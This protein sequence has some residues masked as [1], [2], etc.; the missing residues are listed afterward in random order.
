M[1]KGVRYRSAS[2]RVTLIPKVLRKVRR[3]FGLGKTYFTEQLRLIDL[4]T[5]NDYSV[6][7]QVKVPVGTTHFAFYAHAAGDADATPEDRFRYGALEVRGLDSYSG[8][9]GVS[10]APVVICDSDEP[11]GGSAKGQALMRL[12]ND[13]M[14]T[15]GPEPAPDDRLWTAND[16]RLREVY[17]GMCEFKTLSSAN[18]ER[19]L[20]SVYRQVTMIPDE[21]PG[22]LLGDA[23]AAKIAAACTATPAP[24]SEVLTLSDEYQGFPADLYLPEGAA[25]MVWDADAKLYVTPA[26]QV[27]GK[28]LDIPSMSDYVFPANLQYLA[29]SPL[30]ASDSLALPGNETDPQTSAT[31][32]QNWQE[33]ISD[34]YADGYTTVSENTQSVAMVDQAHYSVGRLDTQVKLESNTLYDAFGKAIDCTKG[35]TLKGVLVSGQHEVGYDFEPIAG[36]PE[37]VLYDTDIYGGPQHVSLSYTPWNHT[38]GLATPAD[39]NELLALELVNDGPDFQGADGRIAHGATFYLVANL[40]PTAATNYEK[41]TRDRIFQR[42]HVTYVSMKVLKGKGDVNGDGTPDTDRNND[43]TPDVYTFDP[44]TGLPDGIDADGDGQKEDEYD[45]NGD[46][47][48][49]QIV[50]VDSNGDGKPDTA[51][52][53]TNGDGTPD[54]PILPDADGNWPDTPTEP[55]GLATAT[56]GIPTLTDKNERRSFGLSVDLSWGEG[57]VFDD[58]PL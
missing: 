40:Q 21:Y 12:L 38:L 33:L 35:F 24:A 26:A 37:H 49:D 17:R 11:Q 20:G 54:I 50:T 10:F 8:N 7:C 28:G 39:G 36:T 46:G 53:D 44:V 32:Y 52:W 27:Y 2:R 23:I 18:V 16:E 9:S 30:V 5:D 41:G 45:I 42:D 31:V 25:R 58:I 34:A 3:N 4:A 14:N 29:L 47:T 55:S 6:A 15:V 1:R 13:V 43:G 57:F 22:K 51:G 19:F 48:P 56:Y